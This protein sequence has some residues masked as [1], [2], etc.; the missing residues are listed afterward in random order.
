MNLGQSI[1]LLIACLG[2]GACGV[3]IVTPSPTVMQ[4]PGSSIAPPTT[5]SPPRVVFGPTRFPNWEDIP[6]AGV[7]LPPGRVTGDPAQPDRI[8]L[9]VADGAEVTIVGP[10]RYQY[11]FDPTLRIVDP[12][13]VTVASEGDQVDVGGY[14]LSANPPTF[15]LCDIGRVQ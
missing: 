15:G 7:P 5:P 11:V 13:G 4:T 14:E 6:C 1:A 2:S 10:S 8:V 12:F 9:L 3:P